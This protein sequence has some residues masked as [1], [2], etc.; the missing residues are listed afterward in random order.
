MEKRPGGVMSFK[1]LIFDFDGIITDTEPV[2][3]EAW[4]SVLEPLGVLIDEDEFRSQYVGL[5]DRDFLD[6]VS[7]NHKHHFADAEK[8]ELI[9]EKTIASISLLENG[10]PLLPGVKEF[11]EFIKDKY[12]LAIC[13]GANRAEIEFILHHLKWNNMFDPI[14]A[15]DSVIKGK[16]D[17]EGYIRALEKLGDRASEVMLAEHV[18]AIEDSPKG[19]AAAKAAGLRCLAVSNSFT[20]GDLSNADWIKGSLTEVDLEELK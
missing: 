5:N 6:A 2:H 11:I 15:S 3:M 1:A 7:K 4:Q 12:F 8:P 10:I 16:P 14:I 13:S 17:P 20:S 19:I 9:E 18:L